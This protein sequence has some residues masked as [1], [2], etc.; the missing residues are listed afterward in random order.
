[1]TLILLLL[2]KRSRPIVSP[3]AAKTTSVPV[4]DFSS[5][6]AID[7]QDSSLEKLGSK[8]RTSFNGDLIR[9]GD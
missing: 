4:A 5:A 9:I 1:M 7:R 3:F 2:L 6:V 8:S